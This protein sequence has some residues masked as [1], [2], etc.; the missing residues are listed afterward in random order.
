MAKYYKFN[1]NI[2]QDALF[3]NL[4]NNIDIS[5][6]NFQENLKKDI[7]S[8][9]KK[10]LKDETFIKNLDFN[11]VNDDNYYRVI[12]NNLITALWF[13][14]IFP[15]NI[16]EIIIKKIFIHEDKIYEFDKKNNILV[17]TED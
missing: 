9:L 16:G 10:I 15:L 4:L 8:F 2:L 5:T 17:I 14:G 7:E 11:I 13:S 1:E 6:K 3:E 12:A